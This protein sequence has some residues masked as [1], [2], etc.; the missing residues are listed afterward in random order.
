MANDGK[1][2]YEQNYDSLSVHAI[3]VFPTSTTKNEC[4]LKASYSTHSNLL[5]A[6]IVMKP[7]YII[8][9]L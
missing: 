1:L 9:E 7:F 8:L 2:S 5:V 4:Q 6:P 3:P